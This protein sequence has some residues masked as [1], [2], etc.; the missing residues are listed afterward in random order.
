MVLGIRGRVDDF[1]K[2]SLGKKSLGMIGVK[3]LERGIWV[4]G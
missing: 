1:A 2:G 4:K 3:S